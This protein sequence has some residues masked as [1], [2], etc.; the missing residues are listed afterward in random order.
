MK[1]CACGCNREVTKEVNKYIV[2]HGKKGKPSTLKGKK[3]PKLS[4]VILNKWKN[5]R[6][7]CS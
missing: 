6:S 4:L 7:L 1:L 5:K 3:N 2:G